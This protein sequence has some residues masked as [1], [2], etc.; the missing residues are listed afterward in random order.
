MC[1]ILIGRVTKAQHEAA[2]RQNPDGF[3][4]FTK[5]TGLVKAPTAK[6]V[7]E[8]LYKFGIW[9]YRI[10]TSGKLD[11]SNIHPFE[12]CGGRYLLYHNGVLGE[13]LGEMSDTNALAVTLYE[14]DLKTA[15][16]VLTALSTGQ[17]FA[18]VNAKDPR[19]FE[20]FGSWSCESGVLMSHKMYSY[21]KYG[22]FSLGGRYDD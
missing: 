14:V 2:K 20:L 22:K 15:R 17:R 3:S 10:G 11:A 4:M 8:G 7:K 12:V 1:I 6:Q 9:H 5:D 18:L 21:G 16:S 13:G 19:K